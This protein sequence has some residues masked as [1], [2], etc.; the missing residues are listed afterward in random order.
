[1]IRATIDAYSGSPNPECIL[2]GA[3]ARDILG[4]IL[5]HPEMVVPEPAGYDGLGFRGIILELLSDDMPSDRQIPSIF[6][7]RGGAEKSALA[8]TEQVLEAMAKADRSLGLE[9]DLRAFF[10]AQM[11]ELA[12]RPAIE[13]SRDA[14][15]EPNPTRSQKRGQAK[16]TRQAKASAAGCFIELGRF[17]PGFW[18]G[19]S[20][21]G[22]NNC[23]NYASNWR[24]NT[25]AQP[26]R[27][28]GD[29]IRQMVCSDV[30]RAALSDGCHRRYDCFPDSEKPRWLM[31]MVVAPGPGFIDYHW[32]RKQLEGFWGHKPGGT[33][34][35]NVDN[36]GHVV[37]NP[38]TAARG[39]YRDFCG[40]FY[41]GKTQRSRMR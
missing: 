2:E 18:N 29:P 40:Y 28:S 21:I 34:A 8:V 12:V 30:T 5:K 14:G 22:R 38:E 33:A 7:I 25:F 15:G 26:G 35:R 4:N 23:Y 10:V 19:P 16:R 31:A 41:G 6:R 20:V 13:T 37:I 32:Y 36:N 11:R 27:G 17:N 3:A 39:P 1:M 24:T 9:K